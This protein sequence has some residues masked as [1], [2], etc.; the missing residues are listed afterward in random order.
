MRSIIRIIVFVPLGLLLLFFAMANRGMVRV[1]LDPFAANDPTAP[2]FE[3][4]LFLV[5]LASA[6]IGVVA[7]SMSTWL[8][9]R[10]HRRDAREARKDAKKARA[11]A[12]ELRARGLA[13][14]PGDSDRTSAPL[15]EREVRR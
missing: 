4:P 14:I 7:G 6:A 12:E 15:L 9:H 8:S 13:S 1:G 5:A 11:E 10:R 3:A 2:S